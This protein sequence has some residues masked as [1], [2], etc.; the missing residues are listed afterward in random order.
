MLGGGGWSMWD[1]SL[2]YAV[3]VCVLFFPFSLVFFCRIFPSVPSSLGGMMRSTFGYSYGI[4][5]YLYTIF[6]FCFTAQITWNLMCFSLFNS[7][8][9]SLHIWRSRTNRKN[10]GSAVIITVLRRNISSDVLVV[11]VM[12]VINTLLHV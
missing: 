4:A 7:S 9:T 8:A 3:R 12:S 11:C 5:L 1:R 2:N 6:A 10:L